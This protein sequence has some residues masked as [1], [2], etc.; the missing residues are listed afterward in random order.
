MGTRGLGHWAGEGHGGTWM[1]GMGRCTEVRGMGALSGV[2]CV[3]TGTDIDLDGALAAEACGA[4][5]G[6]VRG[7]WPAAGMAG[8]ERTQ[9][10]GGGKLALQALTE[11]GHRWH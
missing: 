2:V 8:R 5:T 11:D 7:H 1:T 9:S 4:P 6:Q 3:G 10:W